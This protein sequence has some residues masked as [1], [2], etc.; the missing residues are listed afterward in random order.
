MAN[1]TLTL[2][3][4][5]LDRLQEL[6]AK[7]EGIANMVG[8]ADTREAMDRALGVSMWAVTDFLREAKEIVGHAEKRNEGAAQ[9]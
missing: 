6:L 4:E 3:L 7:S 8:V 9:T 2:S 1:M 5:E